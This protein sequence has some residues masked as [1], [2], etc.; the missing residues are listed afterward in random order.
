M[1]A[2][3][4]AWLIINAI[5][6]CMYLRRGHTAAEIADSRVGSLFT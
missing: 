3:I 2:L 1:I 6:L 5:V 4:E